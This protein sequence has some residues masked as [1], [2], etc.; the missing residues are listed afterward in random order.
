[1]MLRTVWPSGI[2]PGDASFRHVYQEFSY[3]AV[4][5]PHSHNFFMQIMI[6]YGILGFIVLMLLIAAFFKG[7]F[8]R[9]RNSADPFIRP[10]TAAIAAGM[11]GLLVQGMTDY[12]WYNNRIT[13]Y[14]WFVLALGCALKSQDNIKGVI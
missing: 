8:A 1:M 10:V 9:N 11:F 2:G 14:F 6:D 5:A 13:A 4:E 7:L 12:T 3:N